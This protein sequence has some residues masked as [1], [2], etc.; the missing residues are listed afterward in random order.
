M[1]F[2]S[3]DRRTTAQPV[4]DINM[5]PLIDVLLVLLVVLLVAAPLV[6]AAVRVDLPPTAALPAPPPQRVTVAI[7]AAGTRHWQ[8]TPVDRD[9]LQRHL[10]QAAAAAEPPLLAIE[11]DAAVPYRAVAETLAAA[12]AAGLARI[13]FVGTPPPTA[14][15]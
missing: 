15:R 10:A 4:A 5:V 6:T 1:P 12:A 2:A 7:D 14:S 3:F 11:A 9:T 13:G 8:G